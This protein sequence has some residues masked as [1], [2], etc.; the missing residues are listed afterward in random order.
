MSPK[1]IHVVAYVGVSF[2]VRLNNNPFVRIC[3]ILFI[4]SSVDGHRAVVNN[5]T[6]MGLQIPLQDPAFSS[7]GYMLGTV[8]RG[9]STNWVILRR[10][11]KVKN[12]RPLRKAF[13][14]LRRVSLGEEGKRRS[15]C[16][17][18]WKGCLQLGEQ[19]WEAVS[20]RLSLTGGG[21]KEVDFDS[22][23]RQTISIKAIHQ[24]NRLPWR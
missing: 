10:W 7:V 16:L 5:A 8:L 17:R 23:E 2:L 11:W 24:C 9:I 19:T 20:G 12:W 21:Y 15:S 3:Y 4:H 1:F 6:N 14:G 13:E 18:Y 22:A